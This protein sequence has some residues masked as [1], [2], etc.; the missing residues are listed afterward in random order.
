MTDL[1]RRMFLAGT[2][3]AVAATSSAPPTSAQTP[4]KGGTLRFIPIGDQ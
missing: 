3:A 2:A 1:S 4:K